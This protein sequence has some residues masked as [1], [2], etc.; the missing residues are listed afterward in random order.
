[1]A[2]RKLKA[3]IVDLPISAKIQTTPRDPPCPQRLIEGLK[4]KT[5]NSLWN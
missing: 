1:M 4:K 3:R 5:V 2:E